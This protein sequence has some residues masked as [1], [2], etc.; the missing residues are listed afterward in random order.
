MTEVDKLYKAYVRE[1]RE[2]GPA[3]PREYVSRLEGA[4]RAEL[5]ALIDS[6]LAA[7][8]RQAPSASASPA[9][10]QVAESLEE[11]VTGVGGFWP[12]MLPRLRDGA[13]L[14]RS[15]VVDRLASELGL[16]G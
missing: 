13:E 5:I 16:V 2:G 3:D 9:V 8:P 11:S 10:Q 12:A 7:A 6:Y 14:Q 4:D 1:H 15:Q